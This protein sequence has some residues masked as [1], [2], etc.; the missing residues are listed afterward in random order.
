M[1]VLPI[2][3]NVG[4]LNP[5]VGAVLTKHLFYYVLFVCVDDD[6]KHVIHKLNKCLALQNLSNFIK[7]E[8]LLSTH[9][10]EVFDRLECEVELVV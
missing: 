10:N 3:W 1:D 5:W 2:A 4:A 6:V 7:C 9:N 8:L